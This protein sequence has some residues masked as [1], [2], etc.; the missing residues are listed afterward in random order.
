MTEVSLEVIYD[1]SIMFFGTSYGGSN[2]KSIVTLNHKEKKFSTTDSEGAMHTL[3]ADEKYMAMAV[4][5]KDGQQK[6][7]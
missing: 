4:Y 7:K 2:I 3:F 1:D 5:D 6:K